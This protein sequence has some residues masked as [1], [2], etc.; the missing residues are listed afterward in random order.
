MLEYETYMF[1]DYYDFLKNLK[2]EEIFIEIKNRNSVDY[3]NRI[4]YN[5]VS[6]YFSDRN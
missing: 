1:L 4:D 5:I 6:D 3:F 2:N